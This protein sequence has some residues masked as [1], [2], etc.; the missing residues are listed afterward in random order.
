VLDTI[1]R[2]AIFTLAFM[3]SIRYFQLYF[4]YAIRH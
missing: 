2:R 3:K 4:F 1:E